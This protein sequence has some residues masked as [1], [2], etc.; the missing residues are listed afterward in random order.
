MFCNS[1]W[2]SF[3]VEI[4]PYLLANLCNVL[5]C[6]LRCAEITIKCISNLVHSCN[7]F[8]FSSWSLCRARI[9]TV[10]AFFFNIFWIQ[11][12]HI[13]P[14]VL[15]AAKCPK[16]MQQKIQ[17]MTKVNGLFISSISMIGWKSRK[18][19]DQ[20]IMW[21]CNKPGR[22]SAVRLVGLWPYQ[23]FARMIW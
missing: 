7:F 13:F 4:T 20:T 6:L 2:S 21:L 18:L 1:I 12:G 22:A 8:N 16:S 11:Q 9:S 5:C 23:Y 14:F 15:G 19:G 3:V 17:L 10:I